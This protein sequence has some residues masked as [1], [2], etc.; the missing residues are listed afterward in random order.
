MRNWWPR[1][2][3]HD[4]GATVLFGLGYRHGKRLAHAD[5]QPWGDDDRDAGRSGGRAWVDGLWF[6]P[7]LIFTPAARRTGAARCP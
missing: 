1:W 4:R 7:P 6:F 5:D 2:V 3:R